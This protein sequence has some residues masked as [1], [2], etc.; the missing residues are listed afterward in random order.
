MCLRG[1]NSSPR[2]IKLGGDSQYVTTPVNTTG[3]SINCFKLSG[4]QID[5][6]YQE[7]FPDTIQVEVD[8]VEDQ[9]DK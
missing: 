8:Q 2:I 4:N 5:N 1:E 3:E 9:A 6:M 7:S